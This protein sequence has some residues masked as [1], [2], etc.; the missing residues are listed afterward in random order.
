MLKGNK[1]IFSKCA[2]YSFVMVEARN[3]KR[4]TKDATRLFPFKEH[5]SVQGCGHRHAKKHSH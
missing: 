4:A 3:L 5:A 1:R 2:I